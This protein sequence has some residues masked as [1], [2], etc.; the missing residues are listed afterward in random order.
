MKLP[1]GKPSFEPIAETYDEVT[2]QRK[3]F[4]AY[5]ERVIDAL[6]DEG[7][8]DVDEGLALMGLVRQ[9]GVDRLHQWEIDH[10]DD[11]ISQYARTRE[12]RK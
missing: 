12:D 10:T 9:A 4:E 3:V 7:A 2:Q 11:T 6:V 1:Y 8:L 5:S